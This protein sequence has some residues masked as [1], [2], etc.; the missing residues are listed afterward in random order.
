MFGTGKILWGR[1]DVQRRVG[2]VTC[3]GGWGRFNGKV[4]GAAEFD[5]VSCSGCVVSVSGSLNCVGLKESHPVVQFLQ[6]KR[7]VGFG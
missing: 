3:K 7:W 6:A 2:D 1:G 4:V 5:I